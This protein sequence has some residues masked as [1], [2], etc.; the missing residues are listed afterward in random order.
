M[1]SKNKVRDFFI[2]QFNLIELEL[3]K[4][5]NKIFKIDDQELIEILI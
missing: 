2:N 5:A 4:Y 1:L 3:V